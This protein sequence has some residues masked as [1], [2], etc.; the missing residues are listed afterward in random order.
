M[1]VYSYDQN[2][3]FTEETEADES[4]LEPG[5]FLYPANS[6]DIKPPDILENQVAVFKDGVWDILADFTKN[7][8][9]EISPETNEFVRVHHFVLGESPSAT[10]VIADPPPI[11]LHKPV[12]DSGKWIEGLTQEEL[13]ILKKTQEEQ[14]P[15]NQKDLRLIKV[16]IVELLEKQQQEKTANQLAIAELL[17]LLMEGGTL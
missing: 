3:L 13:D 1:K 5:I 10:I 12:L 8:A 11:D 14:I 7:S 9:V 4:P 17:E 2:G 15:A 16:G 6:T